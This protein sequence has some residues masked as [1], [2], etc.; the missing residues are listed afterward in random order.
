MLLLPHVNERGFRPPLLMRRIV[1]GAMLAGAMAVSG[2]TGAAEAGPQ[3]GVVPGYG[4]AC[5]AGFYMCRLPQQAPAGSQCTCPGLGAP[6]Y[7][8]VR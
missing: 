7:G 5:Y 6:S 3:P 2:C 4:T 1:A 8:T